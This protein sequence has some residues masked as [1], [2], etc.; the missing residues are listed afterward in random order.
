MSTMLARLPL[1]LAAAAISL[2]AFA[3]VTAA[4]PAKKHVTPTVK[5]TSAKLKLAT[6]TTMTRGADGVE[7][8]HYVYGPIHI[9]PGQNSQFLDPATVAMGVRPN[10]NGYI[11]S[12]NPNLIEADGSIPRVDVIHLHHAVWAVNGAPTFGAGEE[13]TI[14][15]APAGYGWRYKTTDS[16][17]ID[18]MIHNL[19]ASPD[20]VY[21]TYDIDFLPDTA[22]QAAS[23]IPIR[24]QW[25]DV[26]G[27]KGYPVFDA[28]KGTGH[29]T[30]KG[31]QYTYPDDDPTAYPG[32]YRRNEW[33]VTKAETL[34]GTAGHLHPGGLNTQLTITRNGVT[35]LLFQSDAKY[36][37]PAGAVSWDVSMTTTTPKWK[38]NVE[39]GDV[40]AVHATYDTSK[41]SWYESMGIMGT[42]VADGHQGVDPFTSS[43]PTRGPVSH[44]PLAEN[45]N[46]GD[47]TTQIYPDPI[48][49]LDGPVSDG[50]QVTIDDF[51]YSQG[52]LAGGGFP[53][54]PPVL[55]QGQT[56]TFKNNDA[57]PGV[58]GRVFGGSGGTDLPA[59]H[60]IT[61]CKAPCNRSSG[62]AYPLA[63]GKVT[64]DSGE[65][66]YGPTGLTASAQRQTWTVPKNLSPGT[67]TYFCRVHPFMRGSFRVIKAA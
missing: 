27:G 9:S 65:L 14:A 39:P 35:K 13:K 38:I 25:M 63:N 15:R 50:G 62:I 51:F 6:K 44:G 22:P 60:T 7:H 8:F 11:L 37:E 36:W 43:Y 3:G 58:I 30:S 59:Y 32:G 66:G 67:Y 64:F 21:M 16:W 31:K 54:R 17:V 20:V 40:V 12:F 1:T 19:T 49:L 34:V 53:A 42:Q 46:H 57:A 61:D 52:N 18:H 48:K 10:E 41:A 55:H 2:G 26:E 23:L 33:H 56:L 47:K 5:R 24:T 28:L 4:A 29:D 45:R